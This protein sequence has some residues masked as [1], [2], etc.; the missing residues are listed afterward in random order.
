MSI[1]TNVTVIWPDW[2]VS[3]FDVSV[4]GI[5][6]TLSESSVWAFVRVT[7]AERRFVPSSSEKTVSVSAIASGESPSVNVAE[8]PLSPAAEELSESIVI[9]GANAET[10]ALKAIPSTSPEPGNVAT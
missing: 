6:P 2:L 4:A 3:T 8:K 5:V 10:P 9:E 7:V 1:D